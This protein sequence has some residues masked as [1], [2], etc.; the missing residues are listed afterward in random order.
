M[1]S[2]VA[3]SRSGAL[4]LRIALRE[5]RGGLRGFFVFIACIAL[6]VMTIAAVTSFS[7]SLTEGLA[8][9]GRTILGADIA[10]SLLHREATEAERA[11]LARQGSVVAA[12]TMRAMARTSDQRSAL[13]ELKAVDNVYPHFGALVL[14][15]AL[16][17]NDAMAMRD[18]AYGAAVD[19]SLLARLELPLGS[20]IQVGGAT[21][22]LRSV[23]EAEPDKLSAGVAFGPRLLV[24]IEAL[25][26]TGLLQPGSLVRWSY[27]LK[28][29]G[30]NA[31][32]PATEAV[33]TAA[34][35]EL[36]QAGW[37]IRS[38]NN[39]SPSLERNIERFTQFLTLVGL[40]ALLVG[41]VGVANA[42]K[43][44]VER[45]HDTIAT[46]KALGASGGS[47]VRLYLVQVMLLA[48]LG[49]L[50]GAV[51]GGG[52]PFA[53]LS[54]FGLI[55]PLP[56]APAIYPAELALAA[57]YGMLTAL[58]FA[59]W[60]LGRAHD[61]PVSAL[62]RDAVAPDR[63]WPRRR[64]VVAT[65]LIVAALAA[66]SIF[67]SYDRRIATIFVTSA[68]LILVTL[69]LIAA[70]VMAVARRLPRAQSTV[71]RLAVNNIHRPG[72][73]TPTV[74]LSLGLGLALLV[75]VTL[76]DGNLRQ[77]FAAALPERAPAFYFLDIQQADA[78][79]FEKEVAKDAP[80]AALNRVP[81]LRGRI[82]AV[83]GKRPEELNPTPQVAWALQGDRGITYANQAP[84]GS[85]IVAGK[86]WDEGYAGPPLVSL[87]KRI[88]D[89]LGLTVGG[90]I[91]VNVLGRDITAEVANLRTVDWQSLGIN[92]VLVYSPS[93]F[94]GAPNTSI[95][96]LTYPTNSADPAREIALVKALAVTFP[97]VTVVRVKEAI[98]VVGSLIT[99]LIVG[100]RSASLLSILSAI[101]V[102]GGAL[103]ASHRHRVYESVVLKTLGATRMRL[104]AAYA[105]EY[106]VLG[107]VTAAFGVAVGSLA[108]WF[109]V[110]DIMNLRFVWL[111]AP[112][113]V[114]A[115]G[116][117]LLTV[118]L[119]LSGTVRALGQKAAPVLRN[120]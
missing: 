47:I 27:Q 11:F 107:A 75:T 99:N 2:L 31:T 46:M 108:A 15:P 117:L 26:A 110:S 98:D 32:D 109:V 9:G 80:G 23:I 50:I 111:P 106:L 17:L 14:K 63:R 43:A 82:V 48:A 95:G 59:I 12:A 64:Y 33:A 45:K 74:V 86:W 24:S 22:E 37:E 94:R 21:I 119:G 44:Y 3:S 83:N 53:A 103:S 16:P 6:G 72:A 77:Q 114:A 91:T 40:I 58:A 78:E 120:L 112:A 54:L 13:V 28:L 113:L 30:G 89:G 73:L 81:M 10:F 69:R 19:E 90:K 18:G 68:A 67:M 55:L 60:P 79:R 70:A 88:A 25:R 35:K 102:L 8:R 36:P 105:L 62:F 61:V 41:G 96:T 87:E 4:P 29:P 118:T 76:I 65:V 66:F 71:V 34:Q 39:A 97:G 5:L 104:I 85:R 93:T 49:A 56:V 38:R 57:T 115:V 7:R 51:L 1:T 101:L 100:I 20:R 42:V 116:A 84:N 52:L 92:F